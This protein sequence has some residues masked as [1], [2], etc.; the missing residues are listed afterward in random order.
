MRSTGEWEDNIKMDLKNRR[1][2]VKRIVI[3]EDRVQWRS[4]VNTLINFRF[5]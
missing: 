4:L 2:N 1:K 3:A 5:Q